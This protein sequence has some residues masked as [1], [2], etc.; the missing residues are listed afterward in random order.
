M[1]LPVLL[2]G[3]GQLLDLA[4]GLAEVLLAVS[5]TSV[6][7]IK[8]RLKL[9]DASVHS[10]HGL[11][12]SLEGIGVGLINSGLHVL[13]L[14]LQQFLL[15]LQRLG[16]LLLRSEFISEASSINHGTLGLLLGQ[17][18]LTSHLVTVSLES[19]DL[20]FQLHLG[21]LDGLVGAGLV[22]QGF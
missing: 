6:L 17:R 16:E 9:T 19:L 22:R 11:F 18:S 1:V 3:V 7:S 5:V 21:A 14:G 15:S 20:E 8:L 10:G 12:A 2:L 13:D 4:L